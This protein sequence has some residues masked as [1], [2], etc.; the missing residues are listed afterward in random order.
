MLLS[1]SHVLGHCLLLC[2]SISL[3]HAQSCQDRN[4]P[5]DSCE[6]L[7]GF[8]NSPNCNTVACGSPFTTSSKRPVLN[9]SLAGDF[10]SQG[11]QK[12]CVDGFGGTVCNICKSTDACKSGISGSGSTGLSATGALA[13]SASQDMICNSE[14]TAFGVSFG[15]CGIENPTLTSLFPGKVWG[16]FQ[17]NADPSSAPLPSSVLS[18]FS[19][20]SAVANVWYSPNSSAAAEVQVACIAN[21]CTQEISHNVNIVH[22]TALKCHCV[23]GTAACGGGAMDLTGA[24]NGMKGEANFECGISNA[25]STTTCSLK[26]DVVKALFGPNG[27]VLPN[28]EFG[29]CISRSVAD[30]KRKLLYHQ[31]TNSLSTGQIIG[32]VVILAILFGLIA[33]V[34]FGLWQQRQARHPSRPSSSLPPA[35]AARVVWNDLRYVLNAKGS[36]SLYQRARLSSGTSSDEK[37]LAKESSEP[38]HDGDSPVTSLS[39]HSPNYDRLQPK[40]I[41]RG[42]SGSVEPGAMM[43]ILGP[44]GAGKSTFLDILAGQRKAGQVTGTHSISLLDGTNA[45][46]D[47]HAIT[48]GF[49]DQ[50]DIVPATSTVRE[51]LMF[52]ASLKLPEDVSDETKELRVAEVI[53]L[54]GLSHV[55]HSRIGND[56]V[57]GLSGG[58]RRRLSIGLELIAK[59]SILFLDEPTSGLDSVSALRV[60][61]V[62]KG[63]STDA[64]PGCGTTIICS[65]HQPSSQI[66]HAFDYI[67][68]LAPGGRQVYC[69]K[70]EEA[71]DFIAS[72]GLHCPPGYNFADYLLEIACDAPPSLLEQADTKRSGSGTYPA[73]ILST[74]L[75]VL[76]KTRPQ[77]TIMTQFQTLSKREWINL[78]RDPTLFW[79]HALVALVTGVFVGAMYFQAKVTIAGFQNRI[80]SLLFLGAII[81]FSALS[82][83]NNFLHV[84][85][86]FMRER[87]SNYY[88]PPAW[89]LSRLV[90]DLI[91]LRLI[92]ALV[93]SI[94]VYYMVGLNSEADRVLKFLLISTQLSTVQTLYNLFLAAIFPQGGL[95]ILWASLTN[96]FQLAFAGFFVN[97]AS[98]TP[99]LRWAQYLAPL[100]FALEATSVNEVGAGLMIKDSIQGVNIQISA[101]MIME[102]L[103]G[104][105]PNAFWR[106]VIVLFGF[107]A[108]LTF[109]LVLAVY[110]KLRQTR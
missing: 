12:Q 89:L 62:L 41:L 51:A 22:C 82:A 46:A 8:T 28:C 10:G 24:I 18:G 2:L 99:I 109:L 104:F 102:M 98:I 67:C 78:K 31:E 110:Y 74:P 85:L 17:I 32:L 49:V 4:L 57:R 72:H 7:P 47:G 39:P 59:P 69:G 54:L 96:L 42:L 16:T 15:Q 43:A 68:L 83:L 48:I 45:S 5:S 60:V 101:S 80:G 61:N 44:S 36:R 9:P 106:D 6:C 77:T 26:T 92:P 33:L 75:S 93:M 21:N 38:A 30:M 73:S 35:G 25:T 71:T 79:M 1:R 55:T 103:F 84:R 56:E 105:E 23:P 91:P 88:S 13:S 108:G 107:I 58:E 14:P 34:I 53:D 100:K 86:L 64:P 29:E 81:S 94:I 40:Q 70:T 37:V 63:L 66:Y 50:A 27:F 20:N 11:C 65:I 19:A 52:A 97:L 3:T 76:A 87:A 95:A 90:F